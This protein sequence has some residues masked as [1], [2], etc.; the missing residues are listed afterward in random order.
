VAFFEPLASPPTLTVTKSGSGF[1][2]VT[3][4]GIT[5]GSDCSETVASGSFITLTA[6]AA[7][8]ATFTGW[9]GCDAPS[10]AVCTMSMTSNKTVTAIFGG[11]CTPD[12]TRCVSGD[13][14]VQEH[15]SAAGTWMQESCDPWSLCAAN[16]C[17]AACGMTSAPADPTLCVL[18]IADGVNDGEWIY[19]TDTRVN[20]S[21]HVIAG[22]L[23]RLDTSAEIRPAPGEDWPFMWRLRASDI[24]AALFRLDQFGSYRHPVFGYRMRKAGVQTAPV[25]VIVGIFGASNTIGSCD[26]STSSTWTANTCSVVTPANQLLDYAGDFN[27]MILGIKKTNGV[28]DLLDLNY[29]YLTIAP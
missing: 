12:A 22:T 17:R 3:G 25:G 23:T 4:S 29:A 28:I 27:S 13:I 16:A 5:C 1:G 26:S 24:T 18:P 8:G 20:Y 14:E 10:G 2:T 21:T 19:W 15:C 11:N 7:S 6:V 9:S